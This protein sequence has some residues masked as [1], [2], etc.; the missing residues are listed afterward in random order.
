MRISGRPLLDTR[1]D[2]ALF[3][4]PTGVLSRLEKASADGL[5]VLLLGPRGAGKTSLLRQ[6]LLRRREVGQAAALVSAATARSAAGLLELIRVATLQSPASQDAEPPVHD[7][8][9]AMRGEGSAASSR[10][11]LLVDNVAP[12]LAHPV[13]GQLRDEL[14]QLPFTWVV[15][16]A[17]SDQGA[18]LRPPADAFFDLVL[19]LSPFDDVSMR[20][21]LR[22]RASTDELSDEGVDSVVELAGGNPRVALDLVRR[23]ANTDASPA[24]LQA[25]RAARAEVL[26]RLGRSAQMMFDDLEA[27]G[28][29][30][31]SD[32]AML[33][34]LGW[35][36]ARAAQVLEQLT[37]AG[38][39]RATDVRGGPGR[40]RRVYLPVAISAD[41]GSMTQQ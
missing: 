27:T 32:E 12:E 10:T 6:F 21:L 35:T 3:V 28:G 25:D 22:R 1:P 23:L 38:V 34:R 11:S 20:E 7:V 41:D 24:A 17:E 8:L 5:N 9:D 40:P 15:T 2:A 29:A 18:F 30:S 33:S 37:A 39:V 14:W 31:A 36:R 4:D 16:C 19:P 26:A 13:F